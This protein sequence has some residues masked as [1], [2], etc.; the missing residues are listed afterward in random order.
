MHKLSKIKAR[1]RHGSN[2]LETNAHFSFEN[3]HFRLLEP[4]LRAMCLEEFDSDC[5]SFFPPFFFLQ[6]SKEKKK[7]I[8]SVIEFPDGSELPHTFPHFNDEMKDTFIL[9]CQLEYEEK[10]LS[11]KALANLFNF[12]SIVMCCT[13]YNTF[14]KGSLEREVV[15]ADEKI[16]IIGKRLVPNKK[17]STLSQKE[18]RK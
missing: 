12:P 7:N 13:A 15:Y 14:F 5:N 8:F 16:K 18:V 1:M 11:W 9:T 4:L 17:K 6:S 2:F 3:L 10:P